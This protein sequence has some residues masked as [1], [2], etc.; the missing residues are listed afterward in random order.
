MAQGQSLHFLI[1]PDEMVGFLCVW[2]ISQLNTD[3]FNEEIEI[4]HTRDEISKRTMGELWILC[5]NQDL[6]QRTIAGQSFGHSRFPCKKVAVDQSAHSKFYYDI[7]DALLKDLIFLEE[8]DIQSASPF[9]TPAGVHCEG[10]P[11]QCYSC[12]PEFADY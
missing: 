2:D 3:L 8:E 6:C 12:R 4:W 7:V 9:R 5:K 11:C 10:T 1:C